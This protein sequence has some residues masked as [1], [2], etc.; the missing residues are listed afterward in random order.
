MKVIKRFIKGM[1]NCYRLDI[2]SG[3]KIKVWDAYKKYRKINW[4]TAK[5]VTK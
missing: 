2:E 3:I 4:R 1:L 5:V